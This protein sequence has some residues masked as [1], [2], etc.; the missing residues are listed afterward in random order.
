MLPEKLPSL[1]DKINTKVEISNKEENENAEEQK[2]TEKDEKVLSKEECPCGK[3]H[4]VG[5]KILE[6]H[7]KKFN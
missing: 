1:K 3:T 4:K 5:T 6:D 7:K 2:E